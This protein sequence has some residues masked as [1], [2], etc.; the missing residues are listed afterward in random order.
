LHL[1]NIE[2]AT[3]MKKF[4]MTIA[5]TSVLSVSALAGE[6]P[7]CGA[8]APEPSGT[9]TIPGDIA[10]PGFTSPGDMGNGASAALLTILD[11]LF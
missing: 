9:E 6:M 2:G 11:L 5:L 10:A 7:T 8:P 4:L 1:F 3:S